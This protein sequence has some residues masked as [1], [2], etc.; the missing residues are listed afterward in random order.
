MEAIKE[1]DWQTGF[2]TSV[3]VF[4]PTFVVL[5]ITAGANKPII[6]VECGIHAREWIAPATCLYFIDQLA[7]QYATDARIQK[8]V[9]NLEWRI[10]PVVNPDGYD[11]SHKIVGA[12]D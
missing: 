5:Q 3:L 1:A 8:L 12:F 2:R 4:K 9:D 10:Y 6:F 7:T 11:Y